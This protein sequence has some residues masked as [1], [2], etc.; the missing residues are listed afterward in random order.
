M[1]ETSLPFL[2]VLAALIAACVGAAHRPPSRA[3][4]GMPGA[5]APVRRPGDKA[6]ANAYAE[7]LVR[8]GLLEG[9]L[10]AEQARLSV[11]LAPAESPDAIL[12]LAASGNVGAKTFYAADVAAARAWSCGEQILGSG[13]G[14]GPELRP[15]NGALAAWEVELQFVSGTYVRLYAPLTASADDVRRLQT[16]LARQARSATPRRSDCRPLVGH[17]AGVRNRTQMANKDGG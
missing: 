10:L 12:S 11:R 13:R 5:S 15:I 9:G 4:A 3:F 6:A 2:A 14:A 8:A 1:I 16:R 17:A 7:V